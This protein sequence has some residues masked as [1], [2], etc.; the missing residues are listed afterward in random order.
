VGQCYSE[1]SSQIDADVQRMTQTINAENEK[2]K[3][4]ESSSDIRSSD[5]L[6]GDHVDGT[7]AA[8]R[9]V[10]G[11]D[12]RT[13]NVQIPLANGQNKTIG[14]LTAEQNGKRYVTYE[15]A[16]EMQL[17]AN[18]LNDPASSDVAKSAAQERLR[19]VGSLVNDRVSV[20]GSRDSWAT[21][22]GTNVE[23]FTPK[24]AVGA[25]YYGQTLGQKNYGLTVDGTTLRSDT[26]VQVIGVDQG[27]VVRPYL[28]VL[29]DTGNGVYGASGYYELEQ[30][31][32]DLRVKSTTPVS[33][34]N[35]RIG[36]FKKLDQ[37]SCFNS[38]NAPKIQYYE[39]EPYKGMPAVVP[40]DIEQGWYAGTRQTLAGFGNVQAFQSS[41]LIKS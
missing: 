19:R 27:G 17:Y 23:I 18:V 8:A 40:F 20:Q 11:F 12:S 36:T 13:D 41:G 6:F 21:T 29:G 37:S 24:D 22:A 10:D 26:P 33:L 14:Q 4:I 25:H 35:T 32:N 1:K 28:A 9:Y 39:S 30:Q 7:A 3:R 5:S 16:K 31:G 2:I 34:P 38:I 15:E